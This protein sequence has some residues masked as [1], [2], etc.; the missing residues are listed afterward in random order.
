MRESSSGAS[1]ATQTSI[2]MRGCQSPS[3]GAIC[4]RRTASYTTMGTAA[5][6]MG[7]WSG[8]PLVIGFRERTQCEGS[9]S[10]QRSTYTA[11]ALSTTG[12]SGAPVGRNTEL[13]RQWTILQ[14][15]AARRPCTIPVL[16]ADLKVSTRTIRRDLEALQAAGF[17]IYDEVV[18]GTKFWRLDAKILMG[19]LARNALTLPEL[20]ALYYSRA[21]VKGIAGTHLLTDLQSALDKIEAAFPAGMKKFLDRLPAV[22]TA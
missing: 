14:Q 10:A 21:L 19:A 22:I 12:N 11:G 15:L 6:A 9:R 20:C 18:N 17:P 5:M 16:S 3:G 4:P 2:R 1:S 7:V 8:I 13:I